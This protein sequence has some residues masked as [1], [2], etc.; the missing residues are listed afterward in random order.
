VQSPALPGSTH[1]SAAPVGKGAGISVRSVTKRFP[2]ATGTTYTAVADVS[3]EIAAGSFVALVG[4][5]GCGKST[6]LDILA[7]LSQ[8]ASGSV[9]VD[10]QPLRGLNKRA[11]Y[12]AQQDTLLPWRTVRDNVALGP[13]LRGGRG[14]PVD[15]LVDAWLARV[16]L[17]GFAD[18]YPSQLSGGM[19]KRVAIAQTWI[20]GPDIV[21]MDEPL[22]SVDV[23]TRQ[24]V[25]SELLGIWG[26]TGTTA[27]LVTHDLEEAVALADRVVVFSA[28]P[29]SHIVGVHDVDLPRPRDLMDLKMDDRFVALYRDIWQDLRREVLRSHEHS[30]RSA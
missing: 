8:P 24:H 26:N 30:D 3:F 1:A 5:S 11:V 21:L 29:A 14:R 22:G 7:G 18:A 27:V 10:G 25:E 28:G 4:P 6:V 16:G 2:T 15:D 9:E 12:M 19:R 23:H 20:V 17:T 13:R